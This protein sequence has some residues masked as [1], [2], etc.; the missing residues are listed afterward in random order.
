MTDQLERDLTAL[1]HDRAGSVDAP[2]VPLQQ[3]VREG[4]AHLAARQRR[5]RLVVAGAVAAAV[6]VAA[7]VPYGART[8][9]DGDT[10]P[11]PAEVPEVVN[12]S[13][14]RPA[15]IEDLP[16]GPAP[17]VPYV[18][19][20]TLHV[21]GDTYAVPTD[22]RGLR[23]QDLLF[24]SAGDTVVLLG[25]RDAPSEPFHQEYAVYLPRGGELVRVLEVSSPVMP[26]LNV[27][28]SVLAAFA[29]DEVTTYALPSGE[30]LGTLDH[31]PVDQGHRYPVVDADG[32]ILWRGRPTYL[33]SPEVESRRR[34]DLP[35]D[36]ALLAA[37]TTG[38][39]VTDG[40][41][42]VHGT[43]SDTGAFDP[44]WSFPRSG[45][46]AVPAGS[47]LVWQPQY[48]ADD[49]P[50]GSGDRFM[51]GPGSV[52][53]M[54]TGEEVDL[55]LP[56]DIALSG[57]TTLVGSEGR[58]NLLFH[59]SRGGLRC[60]V[61]TGACDRILTDVPDGAAVRFGSAQPAG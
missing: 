13:T 61:T 21:R 4:E 38:V 1:L 24:Q 36:A 26:I 31:M 15:S 3:L 11:G 42:I 39:L 37:T 47:H 16:V 18:V 17:A 14:E 32:R 45:D 48:T 57:W 12:T 8:L 2:P 23:E 28:G 43:V 49:G 46:A 20:D 41:E 30:E 50:R 35:A 19:D 9:A 60:S 34:V 40:R 22:A 53:D 55:L 25:E 7:A 44:D 54:S 56:E 51:T 6:V 29:G 52:A 59:G 27:D 58:E 5:K 10:T 33:W